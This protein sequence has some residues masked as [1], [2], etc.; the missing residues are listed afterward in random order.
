MKIKDL[1]TENKNRISSSAMLRRLVGVSVPEEEAQEILLSAQDHRARLREDLGR[2]V[3]FFVALVDYC[4]NL[5]DLLDKPVLLESGRLEA[6]EREVSG[7]GQPEK[8]N[9]SR[10][11]V[12][13]GSLVRLGKRGTRRS[14][15]GRLVNIGEG[16]ARVECGHRLLGLFGR[17]RGDSLVSALEVTVQRLGY[18][19][20]GDMHL[21]GSLV[22]L[23]PARRR[24][25]IELGLAFRTPLSGRDWDNLRHLAGLAPS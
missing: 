5:R 22:W 24:V 16:G 3:G 7:E 15:H 8:R 23:R 17:S 9:A 19:R 2:E 12:G 18:Q 14:C 6:M 11:I 10:Y 21:Q 4:V 25:R 1:Q 13:R 20:V